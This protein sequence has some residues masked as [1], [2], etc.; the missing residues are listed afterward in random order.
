[1]GEKGIV[2][3]GNLTRWAFPH[4][5]ITLLSHSTMDSR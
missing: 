5:E 1:M 3:R 2:R 4:Y